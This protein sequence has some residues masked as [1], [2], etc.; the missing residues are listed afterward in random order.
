MLNRES[1]PTLKPQWITQENRPY[2][3]HKQCRQVNVLRVEQRNSIFIPFTC[4]FEMEDFYRKWTWLRNL[5]GQSGDI[6]SLCWLTY[7]CSHRHLWICNVNNNDGFSI[8]VSNTVHFKVIN[9]VVA[10]NS[11]MSTEMKWNFLE[12]LLK[13][14]YI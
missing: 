1:E 12:N 2:V 3:C 5:Y 7:L 8:L 10:W 9:V 4:S 13:I 11:M 14:V 6:Y